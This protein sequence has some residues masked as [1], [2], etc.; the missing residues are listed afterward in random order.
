MATT[1]GERAR[2]QMS[3]PRRKASEKEPL[4][5]P[6]FNLLFELSQLFLTFRTKDSVRLS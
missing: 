4:Y 2:I 1:S 3:W 6:L 5:V